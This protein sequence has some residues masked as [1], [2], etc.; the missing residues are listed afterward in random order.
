MKRSIKISLLFVLTLL[1]AS[2]SLLLSAKEGIPWF[3]AVPYML[4]G[5]PPGSGTED[6]STPCKLSNLT[7]FA[8]LDSPYLFVDQDRGNSTYRLI[9]IDTEKNEISDTVGIEGSFGT[10]I[11][12]IH[13]APN[14]NYY[15]LNSGYHVTSGGQEYREARVVVIDPF[16]GEIVDRILVPTRTD[17]MGNITSKGKFLTK[18]NWWD[19]KKG[20]TFTLVD[21]QLQ[22]TEEFHYTFDAN[23]DSS[24]FSTYLAGH[25]DINPSPE[26]Y[27]YF[28]FKSSTS[29]ALYRFEPST[30]K[31]TRLH[32]W[33]Q[34]TYTAAK[35]GFGQEYLYA[36]FY[37][38][39]FGREVEK[40]L[41]IQILNKGTG[42]LESEI[43]LPETKELFGKSGNREETNISWVK[44]D[45][46]NDML[47][48]NV[49]T[50]I[51]FRASS[52]ISFDPDNEEF[53]R[54]VTWEDQGFNG[55]QLINGNLYLR[56]I[57]FDN[58]DRLLYLDPQTG[59]WSWIIN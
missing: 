22:E 28:T 12:D 23:E 1:L 42:R 56:Q 25:H 44:F 53:T 36:T 59:E 31:R 34:T 9:I 17:M 40:P 21:T 50:S 51:P 57:N 55:M 2:P 30:G 18:R 3:G 47:Y 39:L 33:E 27:I 13:R 35:V 48:M 16:L 4:T 49:Q 15:L 14:G 6:S 43:T 58:E 52:I 45:Q 32:L 5:G 26:R 37:P 11:G 7:P 19:P 8:N 41:K 10:V 24:S 46:R 20:I 54:I 38:A 29:A